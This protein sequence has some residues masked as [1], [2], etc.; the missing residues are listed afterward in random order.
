MGIGDVA[1][2]IIA[3]TGVIGLIY[4]IKKDKKKK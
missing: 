1:Q 2:V 3:I 4:R